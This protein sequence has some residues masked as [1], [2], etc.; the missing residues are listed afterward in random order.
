MERTVV[1]RDLGADFALA[2]RLADRARAVVRERFGR[3][4][5]VERKGDGS[6][7]TEVDLAV[8]HALRELV[9]AERPHDAVHGEELGGG[10]QPDAWTWVF[11]PIDGTRA[12]AAGI[13]TFVTLIAL[14]H[15]GRSVLGVIEQPIA[16]QRWSG[17]A[18][19][20][21]LHNGTPVRV[22]PC[23]NLADAIVGTTGP[24]FFGDALPRFTSFAKSVRDVQWGGDGYLYG[25]LAS[26]GLDLVIERGLAVHDYAAVLPVIEGAGGLVTDW[27]GAPLTVAGKQNLIACADPRLHATAVAGLAG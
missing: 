12:F 5:R 9:A 10:V 24:Q 21:T 11:D 15:A 20:A 8:E 22:R 23:A 14:V 3:A 27:S 2:E 1:T 13:P 17:A 19:Q 25:A 26:G 6:P 18:G 16:Q 7:V 4:F